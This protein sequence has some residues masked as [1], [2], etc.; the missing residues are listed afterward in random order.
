MVKRL[1][2][3]TLA[4]VVVSLLAGVTVALAQGPDRPGRQ[5][6]RGQLSLPGVELRGL[7]LTDA[8]REQV[9]TLVQQSRESEEAIR[10]QLRN[11]IRALLTPDQLQAIDER[12]ESREER[13]QE[14]L[15][16]FEERRQE[17]QQS[18]P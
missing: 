17:R 8:L 16:R 18:Q 7:E 5:G 10:E 11:D 14:R 13:V 1:R 4:T 6:R 15:E 12:R 3:L 2:V 9:R